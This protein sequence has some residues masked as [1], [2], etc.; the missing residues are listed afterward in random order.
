[1]RLH[2]LPCLLCGTFSSVDTTT[3]Q[4][5]Y[6]PWVRCAQKMPCLKDPWNSWGSS[7]EQEI[8][9][10]FCQSC[11]I[12]EDFI[13]SWRFAPSCFTSKQ[14]KPKKLVH[15]NYNNAHLGFLWNGWVGTRWRR[16]CCFFDDLPI[17]LDFDCGCEE[18]D[19]CI[20]CSYD[21]HFRLHRSRHPTGTL[22]LAVKQFKCNVV[23]CI[24]KKDS[25]F[26]G[27]SCYTKITSGLYLMQ[28]ARIV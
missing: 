16:S 19:A 3:A 11:W 1:M 5:N 21:Q 26:A 10:H 2:E 6:L 13:P 17:D 12:P 24:Q 28:T 25:S 18:R 8:L 7:K 20:G 23:S 27:K 15:T 22:E 4:L 14:Q 9:I